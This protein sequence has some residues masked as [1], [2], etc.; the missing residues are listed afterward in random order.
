[1]EYALITGASK[2][3][4]KEMALCLAQRNYNLLLVARS[5]DKLQEN[6]SFIEG[7]YGVTVKYLAADLSLPDAASGILRWIKEND[8]P[9]SVLINNA[10]YGLWGEFSDIPLEQQQNMLQLNVATLMDLCYRMI[11]ILER[12]PGKKYI[13]NVGSMAGF[14]AIPTLA[15]YA[16]SKAAV[17][18]FSRG[19]ALELKPKQISVS[20]L[21]PG[22]VRTDFVARSGMH[23]IAEKADKLSMDPDV[24]ARR[25]IEGMF[26]G[27]KEM[28]PGF[29]NQLSV[30]MVKVL[31][32]IWIEKIAA[33]IYKKKPA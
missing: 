3:I 7:R 10:G 14:Q 12:Q 30:F 17:N 23:H 27:K 8:F 25:A 9:V 21:A 15:M 24:I 11:P 31:P 33:S 18:T 29:S 13:L 1:M 19:L 32:K 16:A 4:G 2:G 22:G 28:T 6:A 26:R 20:L 5:A